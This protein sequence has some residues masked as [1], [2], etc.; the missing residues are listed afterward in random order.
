MFRLHGDV[1]QARS[2]A[3][4]LITLLVAAACSRTIT[5]PDISAEIRGRVLRPGGVVPAAEVR[6]RA[7]DR[8]CTVAIAPD[9]VAFSDAQGLYSVTITSFGATPRE[10]CLRLL[11]QP[12]AGSGLAP[13][14]ASDRSLILTPSP[15]TRIDVDIE[16]STAAAG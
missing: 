12:P 8:S 16:L 13:A 15:G 14:T 1:R 6:A 9:A 11:V 10:V 7:L 4:L 5:D 3:L 2:A